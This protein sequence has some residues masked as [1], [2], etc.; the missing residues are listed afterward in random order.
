MVVTSGGSGEGG[1]M[2]P[3]SISGSRPGMVPNILQRA[4]QSP[5]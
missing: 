4:G 1:K 2:P 3:A 5:G